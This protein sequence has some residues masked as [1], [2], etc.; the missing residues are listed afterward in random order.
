MTAAVAARASVGAI[1]LTLTP[2]DVDRALT[3][4]RASDAERARFH[5]PYISSSSNPIVERV[6]IVTELRRL[7]LVAEDHI[8]RGDRMFAYSVRLAQD[9]VSPWK[10]RVSVVARLRFHPQNT[11]IGLPSVDVTLD[12][13]R[14]DAA[15]IGVLKDPVLSLGT[16]APEAGNRQPI[17]GAI[18]EGV[19]DAAMIGQTA[20]NLTITIDGRETT[21]IRLDFAA[22]E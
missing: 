1:N 9:G 20:R 22:V 18:V 14:A 7:V 8:R 3:I 11:Y 2:A 10:G 5:A 21:V 4:A 17:L 6:E 15:R 13:P 19:F 12:G 16:T